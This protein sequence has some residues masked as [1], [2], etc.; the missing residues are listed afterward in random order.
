MKAIFFALCLAAYPVTSV[1]ATEY[2]AT[3]TVQKIFALDRV[4]IGADRNNISIAGFSSAGSCPTNDGLVALA[5]RD[6]DAGKKQLLIALTAKLN[7][8]QVVVRADDAYKTASGGLCY[9]K[10]LELN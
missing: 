8:Y 3:G 4:I 2:A 1:M 6:D 7:N 5:L 9:L 10:Y